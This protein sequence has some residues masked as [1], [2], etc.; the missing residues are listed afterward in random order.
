MRARKSALT[1]GKVIAG[2]LLLVLVLF[3]LFPGG[4]VPAAGA[5]AEALGADL[6]AVAALGLPRASSPP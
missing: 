4:A 3:L 5:S 2:R 6:A 1:N